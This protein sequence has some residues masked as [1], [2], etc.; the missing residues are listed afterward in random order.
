MF[1]LDALDRIEAFYACTTCTASFWRYLSPEMTCAKCSHRNVPAAECI[2]N[3]TVTATYVCSA[4]STQRQATFTVEKECGT[5]HRVVSPVDATRAVGSVHAFCVICNRVSFEVATTMDA[6][7]ACR[8]CTRALS[9]SAVCSDHKRARTRA[10]GP[11]AIDRVRC[12]T[13]KP[14]AASRSPGSSPIEHS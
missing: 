10:L 6:T 11:T 2:R 7:I 3:G 14:T 5:C 8:R 13:L 1:A 4:C 12:A 9:P